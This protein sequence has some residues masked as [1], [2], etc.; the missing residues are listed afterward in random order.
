MYHKIYEMFEK[1]GKLKTAI[2]L[3][4][5][6]AGEKCVVGEKECLPLG[7]SGMDW[8]RYEENLLAACETGIVTVGETEI[9]VEIYL[10]NPHLVI[11]GGGHVSCPVAHIGKMLGFHVVVMDDREAFITE[12]RFPDADQRILGSFEEISEK[13]PTYENAYYVVVTRG[14]QG[15][16]ACARQILKRPYTYF[17]MIGS[18]NKVRITREKLLQE[19]FSKEQLDTIHSPIGLPIGGQMPEE[20]AVSI[21]AEIILVKN[22]RYA[23][24][25]DEKVGEAVRAGK[26][27]TMLTIVNRRG[28]SPRDIGSKMFMEETGKLT[29]SIGGGE[30]EFKAL[31]DAEDFSETM[32][33]TYILSGQSAG[34]LGMICG[35]EV[36]VLFEKV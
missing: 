32:V 26:H 1:E 27:G 3:N 11:L 15:D 5:S 4:G 36:E 16:S 25:A 20:I 18:R 14:H 17:G 31:K 34:S 10:E 35:G 13:I 30:V 7:K 19:G 23:V 12:E 9:F 28:S 33:K 22:S 29:G 24:F 21:L 6:D 2:V 8:K